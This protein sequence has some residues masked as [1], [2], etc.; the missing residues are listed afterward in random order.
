MNNLAASPV[1]KNKWLW[2]FLIAVMFIIIF[3]L[4][5]IYWPVG[6]DYYFTGRPVAEAFFQG[7]SKIYDATSRTFYYA[8][9]SI[10]L[11]YPGIFL[12]IQFGQAILNLIAAAGMV[13]TAIIINP[14]D[15]TNLTG[16]VLA[17]CTL[18]TFDVLIRSNIDGLL[19]LA[20]GLGWLAIQKRRPALLGA[21]FWLLSIKP[22][23]V[24]LAGLAF[25]WMIRHWSRR[26]LLI[27]ILPLALTVLLSFPI[28]GFDWPLRYIENMNA[29]PPYIYLQTSLWRSLA[30]LQIPEAIA[31]GISLL[32]LL[33]FAVWIFK[34]PQIT[35]EFFALL[36]A[37]NLTFS[38]YTLG[39]H[40]VILIPAFVILT[41]RD[42][43][44]C[45][46]WLLTLTP[47]LRLIF[48]FDITPLDIVYPVAM[49]LWLVYVFFKD[50]PAVLT[51]SPAS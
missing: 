39:S 1:L 34:T 50:R 36:L 16:I 43:R 40:Y 19:T 48:G 32:I 31:K 33:A 35:P 17:I 5:G 26:E 18:H 2:T 47:L 24:I 42:P 22:V 46:L 30:L 21:S 37:A 10:F 15:K 4:A 41:A 29:L 51:T 9:W 23:N 27:A 8:P 38:T 14:K 13:F 44:A 6:P 7:R 3:I 28:F 12:P 11:F 49:L 45:L 25:L 20:I